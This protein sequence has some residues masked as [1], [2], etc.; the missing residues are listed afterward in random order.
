MVE[1]AWRE[2]QRGDSDNSFYVWQWLS[3]GL[4]A[5]ELQGVAEAA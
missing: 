3:V 1:D 5:I 2:Y 4:S